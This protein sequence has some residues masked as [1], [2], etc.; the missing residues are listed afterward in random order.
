MTPEFLVHADQL[1]IKIAQGAKPGES[2]HEALVRWS[3]NSR[4]HWSLEGLLPAGAPCREADRALHRPLGCACPASAI[5][6][7]DLLWTTSSHSNA[8]PSHRAL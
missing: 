8:P 6:L 2:W 4:C 7:L 1:E 3:K 5:L